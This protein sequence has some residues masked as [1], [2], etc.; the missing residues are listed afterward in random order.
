MYDP[1]FSYASESL[2]Y[3]AVLIVAVF[4][5]I[6]SLKVQ[7]TFKKYS[8]MPA[9]CGLRA[10]DVAR[11]LLYE[12]GSSA[13]LSPVSGSLTD[14]YDPTKNAV[15]LSESVY[16]ST[17]VAALAVAA[18]EIGHVMQHQEGY[19]PI[20]VRN[21]LL[22]VARIGST[23]GPWLVIIGIMMGAFNLASIGAGLYFGILA[24]QLVTLP[25]EFNASRRGLKM[26]TE[27]GYISYGSEEQAAKKVLRAAA[28]TYVVAALST[29]LIFLRLVMMAS[30]NRR[31]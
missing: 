14:H 27:G 21:A 26:L 6:A 29:F 2:L 10:N 17:S 3:I 24:F 31:R 4:G 22:P 18:H 19:T 25:V 20:K 11:R 30:R 28:M 23:V 9:R 16:N 8:T 13:T 12:G 1:Y 15:G 5:M 7:S